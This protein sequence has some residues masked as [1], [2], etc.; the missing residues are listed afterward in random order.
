MCAGQINP[1]DLTVGE[2]KKVKKIRRFIEDKFVDH[3]RATHFGILPIKK[4]KLEELCKLNGYN[5]KDYDLNEGT[6]MIRNACMSP[7]CLYY[8]KKLNAAEIHSH[9]R[10]WH[11][12][13]PA[14]FHMTVANM[15]RSKMEPNKIC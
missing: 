5:I 14:K 13:V 15:I 4:N 6:G 1:K 11:G 8:M 7:H 9:L 2:G 12:Q 3:F 10:L